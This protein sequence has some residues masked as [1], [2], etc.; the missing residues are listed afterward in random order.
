MTDPLMGVQPE[1]PGQPDPDAWD[2]PEPVTGHVTKPMMF[3][4][5]PWHGQVR[6]IDLIGGHLPPMVACIE[7]ARTY[8]LRDLSMQLRRADTQ[9]EVGK[10]TMAL[11][12]LVELDGNAQQQPATVDAAMQ[13]MIRTFGV[14]VEQPPVVDPSS[15]GHQR[16]SGL[17]IPGGRQ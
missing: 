2:G 7:Q 15:N 10:F 3:V 16:P 1:H 17:I 5:G 11:Y 9:L 6:H 8:V 14:E 12:L 4:G 13:Y